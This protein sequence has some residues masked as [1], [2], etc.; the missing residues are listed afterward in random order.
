MK[1]ILIESMVKNLILDEFMDMRKS[2]DFVLINVLSRETFEQG[3]IPGSINIPVDEIEDEAPERFTK[4]QNL[5]VYCA[6]EDCQASEKA[7]DKLEEIGFE[8]VKDF[9][10]G[11]EGWKSSG[12]ELET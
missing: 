7:A 10:R 3:H 11:L 1:N 2:E 8:N 5:V 9:V 12:H 6:S 4:S